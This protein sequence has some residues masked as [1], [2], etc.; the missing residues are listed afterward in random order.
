MPVLAELTEYC[1]VNVFVPAVRPDRITLDPMF[2]SLVVPDARLLIP[3]SSSEAA[4]VVAPDTATAQLDAN[5][6]VPFNKLERI[7]IMAVVPVTSVTDGFVPG[8]PERVAENERL[9]VVPLLSLIH[10]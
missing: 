6:L 3:V 8:D 1:S 9:V 4:N 7:I 2:W 5:P 10:I